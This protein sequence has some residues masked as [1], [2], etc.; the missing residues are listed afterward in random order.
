[1]S[2]KI[3]L[4]LKYNHSYCLLTSTITTN[5][6][7]IKESTTSD[8]VIEKEGI[9]KYLYLNSKTSSTRYVLENI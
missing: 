7:T 2:S 8:L 9:I 3:T 5:L 1:M 6:V 4:S